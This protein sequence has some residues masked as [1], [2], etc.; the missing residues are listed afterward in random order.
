MRKPKF[1][2]LLLT[3]LVAVFLAAPVPAQTK[4]DTTKK[5]AKSTPAPAAAKSG[6]LLDLNSASIDRSQGLARHRRCVFEEDC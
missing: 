3:C 5:A 2:L 6:T 4:T 1:L